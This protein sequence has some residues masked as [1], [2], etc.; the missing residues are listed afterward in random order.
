MLD[1]DIRGHSLPIVLVQN[2]T[3]ATRVVAIMPIM[4]TTVSPDPPVLRSSRNRLFRGLYA[5]FV[6]VIGVIVLKLVRIKTDVHEYYYAELATSGVLT[7]TGSHE[8]DTIDILTL[9]ASVFLQVENQLEGRLQREFEGRVRMYHLSTT[10]HTSRDSW[11]KYARLSD[12]QFDLVIVCHGINDV[13]MNYWPAD[14]FRPDYSHCPW[15]ARLEND[16]SVGELSLWDRLV[17]YSGQEGLGKPEAADYA[18]GARLKTG[19]P[20]QSNL[21]QIAREAGRRGDHVLLLTLASYLPGDYSQKRFEAGQ[22]DYGDGE[23]RHPVELWGK[24]NQ[25]LAGISEHNRRAR[26]IS[27]E[28]EHVRLLDLEQLIPADGRH[29]SDICH[30]TTAGQRRF[31]DALVSTILASSR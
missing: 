10:A 27:Q 9:G 5:A 30:L 1:S 24:P 12:K 29:F 13:R 16:L 22:L 20:V 2:T 28:S 31:V 14:T 21:E 7:A 15:Y 4:S 17:R 3:V 11:L 8:D 18:H 25:V 23:V 19:D 6:L 26:T